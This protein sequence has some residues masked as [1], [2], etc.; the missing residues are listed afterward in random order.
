MNTLLPFR[1]RSYFGAQ[2]I[3]LTTGAFV[4]DMM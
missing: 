2:S 1:A 3:N 4:A